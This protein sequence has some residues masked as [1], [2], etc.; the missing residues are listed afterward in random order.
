M[1][2]G[3]RQSSDNVEA[4]VFVET[5]S[6]FVRADDE[7]E[8]DCPETFLASSL[9]RVLDHSASHALADRRRR[10]HVTNVRHM[11]AASR[12]V[13]A[14]MV[15]ADDF[16]SI[17]DHE[18]FGVRLIPV[19]ERIGF[20]HVGWEWIGLPSANDRLHNAPY[21]LIITG[22]GG[23]HN[24]RP[25]ASAHLEFAANLQGSLVRAPP[26]REAYPPS[27]LRSRSGALDR[28]SLKK[29]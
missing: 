6:A 11:C 28:P 16:L 7:V 19:G 29:A 10:R 21:R 1:P 15:S 3:E 5:N 13:R 23:P 4:V 9:Q 18:R 25:Q 12:R 24:H 26:L 17:F 22:T 14:Q 2:E 27:A 20:A 8:L